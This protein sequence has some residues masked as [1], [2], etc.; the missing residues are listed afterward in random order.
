MAENNQNMSPLLGIQM[1]LMIIG[2]IGSIITVA[3]T[4]DHLDVEVYN[5]R[6][7]SAIMLS[8]GFV[9][10]MYYYIQGYKLNDKLFVLPILCLTVC[11]L[12][13][14]I[15]NFLRPLADMQILVVVMIVAVILSLLPLF[16]INKVRFVIFCFATIC[17]IT[18]LYTGYQLIFVVGVDLLQSSATFITKLAG[19]MY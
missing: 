3:V 17:A 19:V 2:F 5:Y 11:L 7:V 14:L 1:L 10:I 4:A 8:V 16:F 9:V 12:S 13:S 6:M 18:V 15:H